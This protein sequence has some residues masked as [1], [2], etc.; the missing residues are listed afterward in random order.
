LFKNPGDNEDQFNELPKIRR[1]SRSLSQNT[2]SKRDSTTRVHR[3]AP[4]TT[5]QL[6][7]L[8]QQYQQEREKKNGVPLW[9]VLIMLPVYFFIGMMF[10]S[11]VENWKKLDALYF[12]FVTVT[13]IGFGDFI[14]GTSLL[15][16]NGNKKNIYI[17]AL[18][19]IGGI[20]LLI[21]VISLV[22]KQCKIKIKRFARKIGLSNC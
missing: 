21:M 13:T 2:Y 12:C 18:Y 19:L 6:H 8:F 5:K 15:D 14:P 20:I 7:L 11:R 10:F 17:A 1:Y 22:A 3:P 4:Y 16:K 9:A